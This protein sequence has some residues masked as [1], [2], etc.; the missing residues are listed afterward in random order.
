VTGEKIGDAYFDKLFALRNESARQERIAELQDDANAKNP[1]ELK[2]QQSNS[3]CES[4]SNDTRDSKSQ[5]S[6]CESI[7]NK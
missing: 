6:A 7:S 4:V 3:G 1:K 5:K 2:P